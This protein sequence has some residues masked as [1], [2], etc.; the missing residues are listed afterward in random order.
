M[1]QNSD[2]ALVVLT[3]IRFLAYMLTL[4][5]FHR[6]VLSHRCK[7]SFG[8]CSL[9]KTIAYQFLSEPFDTS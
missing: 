9:A 8:F 7:G 6:Q 4:V 2:Q 1:H 5:F 3:M